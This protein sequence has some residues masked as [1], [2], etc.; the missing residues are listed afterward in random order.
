MKILFQAIKFLICLGRKCPNVPKTGQYPK[1]V[2]IR[3]RALGGGWGGGGPNPPPSQMS[4]PIPQLIPLK[5][6]IRLV[7]QYHCEQ[8]C[9]EKSV[10]KNAT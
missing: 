6:K 1:N 5:T 9:L 10:E 4:Y 3:E 8:N 2:I 7:G